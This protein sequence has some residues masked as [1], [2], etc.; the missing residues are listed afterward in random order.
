[1][2]GPPHFQ[3]RLEEV[4]EHP[5]PVDGGSKHQA[6]LP[7][8][9]PRAHALPLHVLRA[10]RRPQHRLPLRQELG[11]EAEG[12][13]GRRHREHAR[14]RPEFRGGQEAEAGRQRSENLQEHSLRQGPLQQRSR[15]FK[16]PRR[17]RQDRLRNPRT[18]KK[19]P[20]SPRRRPLHLRGQDPPQRHRLH[21]HVDASG[22]QGILQ[23]R[24]RQRLEGHE[25]KVPANAREQQAHR[26]QRRLHLQAHNPGGS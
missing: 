10:H 24:N 19:G 12:F 16:I 26:G 9:H 25:D 8:V 1:M 22:R 5:P 11:G 6:P 17:R 18:N 21:P 23:P 2:P 7:Q 4:P 13:Q 14:S 20:R 15:G 3:P